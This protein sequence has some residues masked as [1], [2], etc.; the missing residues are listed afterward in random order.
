MMKGPLRVAMDAKKAEVREKAFS[1]IIANL[2]G[3][4]VAPVR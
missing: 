4:R 2:I 1:Q 3:M